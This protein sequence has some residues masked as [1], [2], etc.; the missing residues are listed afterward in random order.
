MSQN[1]PEFFS[2]L[3]VLV[4]S[5]ATATLS[6]I[7]DNEKE[8]NISLMLILKL[9]TILKLNLMHCFITF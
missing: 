1:Y 6:W 7:F 8:V 2:Q 5:V 3:P 4:E 9:Q